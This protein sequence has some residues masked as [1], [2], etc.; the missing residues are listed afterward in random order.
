MSLQPSPRSFA[1]ILCAGLLT[2]CASTEVTK[3]WKDESREAK[4]IG[5]VLVLA[6]A[7]RTETRAALEDEFVEQLEGRGHDAQ[8]SHAVLPADGPLDKARVLEFAKAQSIDTILVT[9]LVQKKTVESAIPAAARPGP[10][11]PIGYYGSFG[12]YYRT[13]WSFASSPSYSIE[14]EV[15]VMETNLYDAQ[16]E[17]LFWTAQSDTFFGDSAEKL[18]RSF[19]E[20]MLGEMGKSKL[21]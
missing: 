4:P 19:A 16:T 11:M 20:V 21:L 6:V 12:D 9:R 1:L 3:A 15:A 17:K 2:A 8:A 14:H 13:S 7:P 10:S 18:I 5:K